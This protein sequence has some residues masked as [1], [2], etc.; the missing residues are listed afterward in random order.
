MPTLRELDSEQIASAL[1]EAIDRKV[2]VAVSARRD[3]RW[4][5]LH[6]RF[7]AEK[8]NHIIIDTPVGEDGGEP[9]EFSPAEKIGISFKLKHYKHVCTVT[10]AGLEQ[11]ALSDGT[12]TPA[13]VLCWPTH[14]HRLQRRAYLRVDVP[15]NRVVRVTFWLGGCEAEPA[16]RSQQQ[17]VWS[18]TATNISAGGLQML[19]SADVTEVLEVGDAVGMRLLFGLSGEVARCDA[20][21]RHVEKA[22]GQALMGF[23]FLGLGHTRETQEALKVLIGQVRDFQR[24]S[25]RRA[26]FRK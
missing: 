10:A 17:P 26:A 3:G 12:Q 8:E 4:I 25:S 23:Q 5:S 7:V 15:A 24:A 2:P 6:S 1:H 13:L 20:Q 18:G 21:L 14:M 22:E 11:F 19:S 9:C 16:G